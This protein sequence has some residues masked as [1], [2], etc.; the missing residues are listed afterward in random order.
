MI[1]ALPPELCAHWDIIAIP[2]GPISKSRCKKCGREKEYENFK[3]PAPSRPTKR[4]PVKDQITL[5]WTEARE[6]R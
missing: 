3:A 2:N 6:K 1:L 5:I 4:P